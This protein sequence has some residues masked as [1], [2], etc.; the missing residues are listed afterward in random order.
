M[1]SYSESDEYDNY[2]TYINNNN[3]RGSFKLTRYLIVDLIEQGT[4][5][6]NLL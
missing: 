4:K 6:R 1:P 5:S 2:T 3:L